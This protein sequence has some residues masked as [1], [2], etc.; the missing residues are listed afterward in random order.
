MKEQKETSPATLP[1]PD[2]SE[3][4]TKGQNNVIKVGDYKRLKSWMSSLYWTVFRLLVFHKVQAM[5]C[6]EMWF[7][8]QEIHS[9]LNAAATCNMIF[10][11]PSL[12]EGSFTALFC[13]A[14]V[15]KVLVLC[16]MQLLTLYFETPIDSNLFG[17]S[18]HSSTSFVK[19]IRLKH[20]VVIFSLFPRPQPVV[21]TD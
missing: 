8:D 13:A 15:L 3:P 2:S 9:L 1:H 4:V 7:M 18:F 11:L 5:P 20:N 17:A 10:L 6:L 14:I 19:F 21:I 12:E 16:T